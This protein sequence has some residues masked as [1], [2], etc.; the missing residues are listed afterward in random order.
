M[1]FVGE[2]THSLDAKNRLFIPAKLREGL[3]ANFYVTRKL[4]KRCLA[5]YTESALET[6]AEK[7]SNLPDSEV[8][9]IKEFLFSKTILVSPD[10][11]GR[12]VLPPALLSY[13]NI[14]RNTVIIGVGNHVQIWA[15]SEWQK[16]EEQRDMTGI[17]AMLASIGM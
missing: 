17:K 9:D 7:L 12:I 8:S 6:L 5:I 13:A 4:N 14:D 11:N 3:G 16:E 2:Y 15:E 1:T 10:A